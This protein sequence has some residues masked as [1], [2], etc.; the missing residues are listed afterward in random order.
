MPNHASLWGFA[1]DSGNPGG[2]KHQ[3]GSQAGRLL[4]GSLAF[5]PHAGPRNHAAAGPVGPAANAAIWQQ[6]RLVRRGR[7]CQNAA[8]GSSVGRTQTSKTL[9]GPSTSCVRRSTDVS[10]SSGGRV[11]NHSHDLGF[12]NSADTCFVVARA[13]SSGRCS[14][15]HVTG[16]C[17]STVA[18]SARQR[19]MQ[20]AR[21]CS[22]RTSRIFVVIS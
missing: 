18:R 13:G 20:C 7:W 12:Q 17:N 11:I 19:V 6:R 3:R 1:A 9:P 21:V 15:V 2:Q 16:V 22:R 8:W 4:D 5:W 10:S 14:S